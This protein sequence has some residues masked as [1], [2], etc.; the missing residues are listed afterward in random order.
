MDF[1][2][3]EL[4]LFGGFL[5]ESGVVAF[6]WKLYTNYQKREDEKAR[7]RAKQ[8]NAMKNAMR[9]ILRNDII[10]T[11]LVAEERGYISLHDVENLNDM[12]SCY[13]EL[14]GNGTTKQ[15]YMKTINLPHKG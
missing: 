3:R 12:F 15:L 2:W 8:D 13:E 9:N 10:E 4:I 5:A 14:G 6:L 11:C 1:D 7:E